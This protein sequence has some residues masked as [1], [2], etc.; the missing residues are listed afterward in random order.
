MVFYDLL[1]IALK[2]YISLP[3]PS[4][5]KRQSPCRAQTVGVRTKI[6][7]LQSESLSLLIV[8]RS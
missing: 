6:T 4:L 8:C 2:I 7:L 1:D 5:T 3:S